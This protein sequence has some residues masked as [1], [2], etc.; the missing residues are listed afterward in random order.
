MRETRFY[1]YHPESA[2]ASSKN[3]YSIH[4]VTSWNRASDYV[5]PELGPPIRAAGLAGVYSWRV[6]NGDNIILEHVVERKIQRFAFPG[7]LSCVPVVSF[8]SKSIIRIIAAFATESG[9]EI[10]SLVVSPK[11][12]ESVEIRRAQAPI[13]A[14]VVTTLCETAENN[15]VFGLASGRVGS[16]THTNTSESLFIKFFAVPES[17]GAHSN[18]D[19]EDVRSHNSDLSRRSITGMGTTQ[20]TPGLLS[21]LFQT[22][23][24]PFTTPTVT[25]REHPS[26]FTTP[27]PSSIRGNRNSINPFGA[28]PRS[29]RRNYG[30]F[31][32]SPAE[33]RVEALLHLRVEQNCV[34][35]LHASG[36]IVTFVA[37]NDNEYRYAGE[38]NLGLKLAKNFA[39][40]CLLVTPNNQVA[41]VLTVDEEPQADSVRVFAINLKWQV[42]SSIAINCRQLVKRSG[43]IEKVVDAVVFGNDVIVATESGIISGPMQSSNPD[44]RGVGLPNRIFWTAIEDVEQDAG[45][46]HSIDG[47]YDDPMDRLLSAHRFSVDVIVKALRI[48][49]IPNTNREIMEQRIREYDFG[50]DRN[51]VFVK[52]LNRANFLTV[53]MDLPLRGLQ[54]IPGVGLVAARNC[55]LF[56]FR[57]LTPEEKSIFGMGAIEQ[58]KDVSLTGTIAHLA[59]SHGSA[60]TFFARFATIGQSDQTYELQKV[61]LRHVLRYSQVEKEVALTDRLVVQLAKEATASSDKDDMVDEAHFFQA[62]QKVQETLAPGTSA[63]LQYLFDAGETIALANAA[64]ASSEALPVSVMFAS[65]LGW[66]GR[67]DELKRSTGEDIHVLLAKDEMNYNDDELYDHSRP[68]AK[69]MLDKC[70]GF[71]VGAARLACSSDGLHDDDIECVMHLAKIPRNAMRKDEDE[72]RDEI[73]PD[74]PVSG[75]DDDPVR[76]G[77]GYWLLERT[78][79]LF[80][81]VGSLKIA[82]AA[83]LEAMTHAPSR[84]LYEKMRAAAFGRF[85]DARNLPTALDAMLKPP[86]NHQE[87]PLITKSEASALRDGMGLFIN[88]VADNGMLDWLVGRELPEP[89]VSL[90][91]HT[92]AR[93]ARAAEPLDI[94]AELGALFTD[95]EEELHRLRRRLHSEYDSLY[96][97]YI[98]NGNEPDAAGAGL[99]W[100]ERLQGEG[101]RQVLQASVGHIQVPPYEAQLRLLM[102]WASAKVKAFSSA[103]TAVIMLPEGKQYFVRS[104]FSVAGQE[105]EESGIVGAAWAA[106]RCALAK[107][108]KNC[109]A[110]LLSCESADEKASRANF[111]FAAGLQCLSDNI[112]G[113]QWI[114]ETLCADP[115]VENI[116]DAVELAAIWS[117]EVGEG[118]LEAIIASAARAAVVGNEKFSWPCLAAVL[119][120][121]ITHLAKNWPIVA[122]KAT[123][124]LQAD[125]PQWLI[126]SAAQFDGAAVARVFLAAG[127]PVQSARVLLAEY[128]RGAKPAG[129]A[130]AAIDATI[131]KLKVCPDVEAKR[132]REELM[133]KVKGQFEMVKLEEEGRKENWVNG[134]IRC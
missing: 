4:S 118:L 72:M 47:I 51:A 100:G 74:S 87:A 70:Y 112:Q 50:E 81:K 109:F 97:W 66:L 98:R 44:D 37:G 21:R 132:Y 80:E 2:V 57:H 13:D 120:D 63:V 55:G 119:E 49:E 17:A 24:N 34:V 102:T 105:R 73:R 83:A 14:D 60:Q 111:L 29:N 7:P 88:A 53:D 89:L 33:E 78:V 45:L 95:D 130:Y 38:T 35:A 43:P 104:R 122:L 16:T 58:P 31:T 85:L 115:T 56:V 84:D 1:S 106:R 40:H 32:P 90:A 129:V 48:S 101:L 114:I 61:V 23:R 54:V 68:N 125:P 99:E 108:Q 27:R 46:G 15:W 28:T 91:A 52:A 75:M 126:D 117:E 103:Y 20:Q 39:R 65:G 77:L 42:G 131:A 67:V 36:R 22:S 19:D 133:K 3:L 62:L 71:M 30:N 26:P 128:A 10:V 6:I 12:D 76:E 82:A 8:E 110:Q 25:P 134:S 121:A 96:A 41:A 69:L 79:R 127:R 86:F 64:E 93:R 9:S 59:A 92:I 94:D 123:C 11:D 5:A 107:M 116:R 18:T 113:V 124:Q